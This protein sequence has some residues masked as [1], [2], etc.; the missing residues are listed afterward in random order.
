MTKQPFITKRME[1]F[2]ARLFQPANIWRVGK[3]PPEGVFFLLPF[4]VKRGCA[5]VRTNNKTG[6]GHF[7]FLYLSEN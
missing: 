7:A 4:L 2:K 1:I 6:V 5:G 3:F